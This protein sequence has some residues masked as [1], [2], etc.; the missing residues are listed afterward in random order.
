MGSS[1]L[2]EVTDKRNEKTLFFMQFARTVFPPSFGN[3]ALKSREKRYH[4]RMYMNILGEKMPNSDEI[5]SI[6]SDIKVFTNCLTI[7]IHEP[8]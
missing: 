3:L 7:K 5:N 1:C 8:H 2:G 4:I 6:Y